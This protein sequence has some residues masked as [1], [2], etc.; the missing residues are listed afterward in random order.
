MI[1]SR[2][3]VLASW[4][5]GAWLWLGCAAAPVDGDDSGGAG[6]A[7]AGSEPGAGHPGGQGGEAGTS[8]QPP[9]GDRSNVAV[10]ARPDEVQANADGTWSVATADDYAALGRAFYQDHP[11]AYDFL[12]VYTEG[13]F[14]EFFARAVT[15]DWTISGIDPYGPDPSM[16]GPETAGS[17]GQ[18]QQ[19]NVMNTPDL[20]AASPGATDI[21]IHETVHRWAAYADVAGAPTPQYLLEG[22]WGG[23]WNVHAHTGGPSAVGYG[24][25]TDVGG[26]RF[27][28]DV[29]YP[30]RMSPLELYLAGLMAPS[31]VP[32]MFY[33]TQPHSYDPPAPQFGGQWDLSSYGEDVSFSGTRVDF[34]I[35]DVI[36]ANG[37]RVPS[38]AD[39]RR[40]F[41]F[42]FVLVCET[43]DGCSEAHLDIVETQR[44]AFSDQFHTATDGRATAVTTL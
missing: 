10:I 22:Q 36:A 11:D 41:R 19:I 42:A 9:A 43:V 2:V 28:F 1:R 4:L 6:V 31:E 16:P 7:G 14:V 25:L 26:G 17:A 27:R 24:D 5:L 8:T 38:S 15:V 23:H 33:V 12:V 29:R 30:L 44:S 40:E 32:A 34:D 3:V 37:P 35:D 18:L 13:E 21:A 20:Y 39:A